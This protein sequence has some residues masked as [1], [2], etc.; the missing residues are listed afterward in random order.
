MQLVCCEFLLQPLTNL[1]IH[2]S[3]SELDEL[4]KIKGPLEGLQIVNNIYESTDLLTNQIMHRI[5][6]AVLA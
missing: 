4:I 1:L 3:L 6:N 2:V 5:Y